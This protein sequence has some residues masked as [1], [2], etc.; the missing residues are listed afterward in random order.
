MTMTNRP[1]E[2]TSQATQLA[3]SEGEVEWRLEKWASPSPLLI[4]ILHT[5]THYFITYPNPMCKKCA[6]SDL[7]RLAWNME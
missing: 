5:Y 6:K 3:R 4:L 2:T 7:L 1:I